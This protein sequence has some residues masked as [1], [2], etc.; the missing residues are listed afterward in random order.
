VASIVPI[1]AP[2]AISTMI[3]MDIRVPIIRGLTITVTATT[4]GV[5]SR[6][7][8]ERLRCCAQ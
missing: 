5:G 8:S 1:I 4:I 3:P 2:F 7:P 6:R